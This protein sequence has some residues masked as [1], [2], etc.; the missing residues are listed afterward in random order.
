MKPLMIL[1]S[2]VGFVIGAGFSLAGNC[3]WPIV[4]W[5]ACVGALLAGMLARWW[6]GI[7]LAGLQ[8]ASES[9]R[10]PRPPVN[11]ENKVKS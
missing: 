5:R 2:L 8:S 6:S 1:G 3:P 10:H 11:S 4:L 9:R 7:W